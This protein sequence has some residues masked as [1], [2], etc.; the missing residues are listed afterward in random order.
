VGRHRAAP[1]PLAPGGSPGVLGWHGSGK[2]PTSYEGNQERSRFG[3]VFVFFDEKND[4]QIPLWKPRARRGTAGPDYRERGGTRLLGTLAVQE[5]SRSAP[6]HPIAFR[7]GMQPAA[8]ALGPTLLLMLSQVSVE[9]RVDRGTETCLGHPLDTREEE[10]AVAPLVS[11]GE[12][13]AAPVR[14][15]EHPF[16]PKLFLASLRLL[17]WGSPVQESFSLLHRCVL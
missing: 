13:A 4:G 9:T 2:I 8:V 14:P 10:V 16:F 7:R 5:C 6:S 12:A 11:Q 3:A 1:E 15:F 17:W